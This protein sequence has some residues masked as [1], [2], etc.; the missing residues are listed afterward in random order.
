MVKESIL[1]WGNLWA[2]LLHPDCRMK[3]EGTYTVCGLWTVARSGILHIH[4]VLPLTEVKYGLVWSRIRDFCHG[5]SKAAITPP[6][7]P[8][9]HH[10][11]TETDL[12]VSFLNNDGITF[13]TFYKLVPKSYD[14]AP[15]TTPLMMVI[16]YMSVVIE[17]AF[18]S[19]WPH[20]CEAI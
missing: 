15:V 2:G 10:H 13:I 8:Q 3:R 16:L 6:S 14:T 19:S 20:T 7:S 9:N 18:V 12:P 17:Y 4:K 11:H 1:R 5:P